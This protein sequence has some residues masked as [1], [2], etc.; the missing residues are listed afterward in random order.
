[1]FWQV[2]NQRRM[3][4]AVK[5]RPAARKTPASKA[6]EAYFCH[7]CGQPATAGD[8]FCR[9]CGTELKTQ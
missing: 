6:K 8:R 1:M 9:S 7:N 4:P 2:Y 5:P 3:A